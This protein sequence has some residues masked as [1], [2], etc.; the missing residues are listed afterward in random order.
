MDRFLVPPVK[1]AAFDYLHGVVL[2][3]YN[4]RTPKRDE[5]GIYL[6]MVRHLKVVFDNDCAHFKQLIF[7]DGGAPNAAQRLSLVELSRGTRN[8]DKIRA[9][10]VSRSPVAR[11]L[12]TTFRWLGLPLR[13]FAP[14]ELSAVFAFLEVSNA[15]ARDLC[16]A[17]VD[18]CATIDGSVHS[19][20]RVEAYRA[21]L[22]G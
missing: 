19:A 7:T 22:G 5:W 13:A 6:A 4:V 15:E 2:A 14:D 17:L 18:L 11:G 8:R 12:V 1:N 21:T 20:S 10:I 16:A 9:A 3:M